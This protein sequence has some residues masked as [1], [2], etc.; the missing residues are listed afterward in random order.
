MIKI[1]NEYRAVKHKCV[2]VKIIKKS[3][4]PCTL[5]DH[6]YIK[7]MYVYINNKLLNA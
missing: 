5:Q 6:E 4:N 3:R 1:V 7:S 2:Y